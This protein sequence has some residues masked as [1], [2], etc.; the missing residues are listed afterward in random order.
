MLGSFFKKSKPEQ[1]FE[2]DL[3]HADKSEHSEIANLHPDPA[4]KIVIP[5]R[6]RYLFTSENIAQIALIF[7][8]L[9]G[10]WAFWSW[11]KL[12]NLQ[13]IRQVESRQ[14]ETV[15]DSLSVVKTN[16]ETSLNE[17]E[18]SFASLS[19]ENDTLATRLA[20]STNIIRQKETAIREIKAQNVRE[21][22]A[23]RAQIQRLQ[24]IKDRYETIIAVLD[25]KNAAL[26][27]ENAQLRGTA[28]GLFM[29]VSDLGRQLE[30]QIRRTLSAEYKATSFRV[31]MER[32]NDKLT[33]KARRTRE[34][35]ISFELNNVS[36]LFQGNQQLYLV[37]TDDQGVPIPSDNPVRMTINT[38]KGAVAIV[39]QA[40]QQKNVIENQRIVM[41]Y[42]LE[43]RLKKGT[44]IVSVYSEKGLLGVASFRL[45]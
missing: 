29:Q 24:S 7:M 10:I 6:K 40:T 41:S 45:T 16:L 12:D 33:L 17:L 44:Y 8:L 20:K 19:A 2:L 39:A 27:A 35:N 43:D 1:H 32:R 18:T 9:A 28:D 3:P 37:I 23:L 21:E 30:A 38:D 31:E 22:T 42:K 13:K 15:L 36:P 34:L 4:S 11:I 26:T 25:Q 5:P 14:H